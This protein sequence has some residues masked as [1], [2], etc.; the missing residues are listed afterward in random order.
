MH[1]MVVVD[2]NHLIF[3]KHYKALVVVLFKIA[4][5]LHTQNFIQL[6]EYQWPLSIIQLK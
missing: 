5:V 6:R 1:F 2:L 4:K 3:Q